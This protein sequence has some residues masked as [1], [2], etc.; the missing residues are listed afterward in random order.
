ML[1]ILALKNLCF[2][3]L[4]FRKCFF[5][6]YFSPGLKKVVTESHS[7][8]NFLSKGVWKC[9]LGNIRSSSPEVF[10]R[11][12]VPKNFEKFTGKYLRQSLFFNKFAG[13]RPATLLKKRLW[14][15]CFLVFFVKFL[16]TSF[17]KEHLWWLLLQIFSK[18]VV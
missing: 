13:L 12:G 10:C 16:R 11:K 14:H 4:L 3:F 9:F 2:F 18:L 8:S 17:F 7:S 6:S 15:R 5:R 1:R